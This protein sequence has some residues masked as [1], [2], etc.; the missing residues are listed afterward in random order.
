MHF[1]SERGV[2]RGF[3]LYEFWIGF[4]KKEEVNTKGYLSAYACL[5]KASE[6]IKPSSAFNCVSEIAGALREFFGAQKSLRDVV[7]EFEI[8]VHQN[9]SQL[10]EMLYI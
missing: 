4:E 6:N 1:N 7:C 5:M 2:F 9:G 8:G 3:H 10:F